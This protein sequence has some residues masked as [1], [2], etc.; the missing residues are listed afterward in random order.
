MNNNLLHFYS[1]YGARARCRRL[2]QN[3]KMNIDLIRAQN[4][5]YRTRKAC[6]KEHFEML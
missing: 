5:S 1:H 4:D 3:M 2:F 6:Q